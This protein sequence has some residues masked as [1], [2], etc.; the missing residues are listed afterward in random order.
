VLADKLDSFSNLQQSDD[1]VGILYKGEI[2]ED[3][4]DGYGVRDAMLAAG[5]YTKIGNGTGSFEVRS[6]TKVFLPGEK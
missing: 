1:L 4:G 6:S 3:V 5:C 2:T